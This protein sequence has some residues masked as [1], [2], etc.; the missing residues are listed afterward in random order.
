M[1]KLF[2]VLTL[3]Y[4]GTCAYSQQ[5]IVNEFQ[6]SN[7]TTILDYDGESSDWIE[8]YNLTD[9]TINLA[10]WFLS[11]DASE[12]FKW[13]FPPQLLPSESLL[14]VFASDK[15]TVYPGGE[16]HT[17]FKLG[18]GDEPVV[19]SRPDSSLS[20]QTAVV[21]MFTDW[22]YGR[23][24]DA[25]N[26]WY[27][28]NRP[29]PGTFNTSQPIGDFADP[30]QFSLPPGFYTSD[31]Y[32]E[33]IPPEPTDTIYYTLDGSVPDKNSNIYTAP[34]LMKY[35]GDD[36]NRLSLIPTT[37]PG[38]G[39][40][41]WEPP[42]GVVYKFNTVR[43]RV[44]K[45]GAWPSKILSGSFIVDP[46]VNTKFTYPVIS[47]ITDSLNFFDDT[48]GIYKAGV[49][50]DSTDWETAHFAQ[51]GREWERPVHMEIF[52]QD[53]TASLS[54]DIG[55]RIHGQGST[56][57][58]IKSLRLYAREEYGKDEFAYRFFPGL[59]RHSFKRVILRNTGND[60]A[61]CYMRDAF[62]Q[63]LVNN[64]GFDTQD[65]RLAEVYLDGEYWGIHYIRER[66]DKY[67]IEE[68][69]GI[70]ND[71]LDILE[72]DGD[73]VEGDNEHYEHMMDFIRN[74]DMTDPENFA[75]VQTLMDCENYINYAAS[76]I[77][78]K[79][80][81]WPYNNVKYWRKRTAGYQPDAP[82]GHD[83]RW[84]WFMFDT[85]YGFGRVG[86]YDYDMLYK[87]LY[88]QTGWS[89][90][91]IQNLGGN[92]SKP[93][94]PD[95]RNDFINT[96]ADL[97]NTNFRV[98][99]ILARI[100]SM[101]NLLL[102]EIEEHMVRWN[103]LNNIPTWNSRIEVMI[104]FGI[105][106]GYF[107]RKHVIDNFDMIT[108]T[109]FVTL[110]SDQEKGTIRI[111]KVH[112]N[113]NTPG[114]DDPENPYPWTGQYFVGV[115]VRLIA[116]ANEG[117]EFV[118]WLDGSS[119][120]TLVADLSGDTTFT[121]IFQPAV[122]SPDEIV[123]NEINYRSPG[124]LDAG[125]WFE[126]RN[127]SQRGFITDDWN[128]RL[129]VNHESQIPDGQL[130]PA[131]GYMV[132]CNDTSKFENVHPAVDP[133]SGGF[134]YNLLST[135]AIVLFGK[136]NV[137]LDS[138][139]Y[140]GNPPWPA[141]PDGGGASLE[142]RAGSNQQAENWQASFVMGGTPGRSNSTPVQAIK[143]NEFMADNQTTIQAPDGRHSDWL[144]VYN[145]L[146]IPVDIAGLW[147]T[148]DPDDTGK[149]RIPLNIPD[150]TTLAA[151][152]HLLLWA[153]GDPELGWRHLDF[154]LSAGG[155]FLGIYSPEQKNLID[156]VS[157]G[158]QQTDISSGRM[159]D[160]CSNLVTFDV[161]T[162]GTA[163]GL[164]QYI[165]VP[166]GWSALSSYLKPY[167]QDVE[168]IL[169]DALHDVVIMT[170]NEGVFMPDLQINTIGDWKQADAFL[171]KARDTFYI[172]I[173]G[174]QPAYNEIELFEGWTLVPCLSNFE[175]PVE[176]ILDDKDDDIR[177]IKEVAGLKIYWPE[178]NIFTLQQLVPGRAYLFF[179]EEECEVEFPQQ[180]LKN[181]STNGS[182]CP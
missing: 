89:P 81:D 100:D 62:M 113:Q 70:A 124:Y 151:G 141:K 73:V 147:F 17:S 58:N 64:M 72:F 146:G 92:G 137:I 160:G 54:Q 88:Q 125:D 59:D 173:S 138:V 116:V 136:N 67:Y 103:G 114:L 9:S 76:N 39:F 182:R 142:L 102:P 15:D 112:I 3:L 86:G 108:D 18:N 97:M 155:E 51:K 133:L 167:D 46:E 80:S 117:Y 105:N 140:S 90:R 38:Q 101:K 68:N 52:T 165:P 43:A 48:I 179:A 79:Q 98:P 23:Y 25:Q 181:G 50:I 93:G 14:L 34:I 45:S 36:P 161:S 159:P 109:A 119:N 27:F 78:M 40:Y 12:P 82:R 83:G 104:N 156:T 26:G 5:V 20:D 94:N 176:E 175:V 177:M 84:R 128:V 11:D 115:P 10:G 180:N 178:K 131:Q 174:I 19:L 144:E 123:I 47:L 71:E 130:L 132:F 65:F 55:A 121:A 69:Y 106:R 122:P 145:P 148:D 157:F 85:D 30:P 171:M 32:L 4:A 150:S 169:A 118:Q 149:C 56:T 31:F 61:W 172:K 8:L 127:L 120:D 22:S 57:A 21:T 134:T 6:S 41:A 91:L 2:L 33:L 166:A 37:L 168:R 135:D 16:I 111:N 63:S 158:N 77:F 74:N 60:F 95:F 162:P 44:I 99:R 87:V 66:Y 154:K 75:Y 24:P 28:F 163:N 107:V 153:D 152:G 143:I 110:V 35:R 1:K 13:Q 29:T 139:S 129:G 164:N 42:T 53:G 7:D 96:L 49:G 126:I 170:G